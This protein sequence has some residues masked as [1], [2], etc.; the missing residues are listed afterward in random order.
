MNFFFKDPLKFQ[1]SAESNTH[2][3]SKSESRVLN[4]P[5]KLFKSLINRAKSTNPFQD[6]LSSK[7]PTGTSPPVQINPQLFQE[8][9]VSIDIIPTP[10]KQRPKLKRISDQQR[11]IELRKSR[12]VKFNYR[13]R[14]ETNDT[15]KD[16]TIKSSKVDSSTNT[17]S[18][19]F[20]EASTQTDACVLVMPTE[21][22]FLKDFD[23]VKNKLIEIIFQELE[24]QLAHELVADEFA[25]NISKS[26]TVLDTPDK[27]QFTTNLH[28]T[29]ITDTCVIPNTY[30]PPNNDNHLIIPDT[31]AFQTPTVS[32]NNRSR[33]NQMPGLHEISQLNTGDRKAKKLLFKRD[34]LPTIEFIA[35]S[36]DLDNQFQAP[37]TPTSHL[38]KLKQF[39]DLII[40]DTPIKSEDLL[41][42]KELDET[43]HKSANRVEFVDSRIL[44]NSNSRF[45]S[46]EITSNR[47]RLDTIND[48]RSK[49]FENT[50]PY[51]HT[52]INETVFNESCN[53]RNKPEDKEAAP[54]P[55][56]NSTVDSAAK[57]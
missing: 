1:K 46:F 33:M 40:V 22:D 14:L 16:L 47:T 53:H 8:P 18:V 45:E 10:V 26:T 23:H 54:N 20:I 57:L 36:E 38:N 7:S 2:A 44:E 48:D 13:G 11:L 21:P 56:A 19:T 4:G 42:F 17:Q 29:V 32:V 35:K 24:S 27:E 52:D 43:L 12:K 51:E 30:V 28:S 9:V 15:N 34:R 39:N 37:R 55:N 5:T 3:V 31:C 41:S 49:N 25:V 6:T 50:M